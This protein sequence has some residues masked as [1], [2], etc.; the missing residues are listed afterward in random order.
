MTTALLPST[1]ALL[2]RVTTALAGLRATEVLSDDGQQQ[3]H[4]LE[5]AVGELRGREDQAPH[6]ALYREGFALL[7]A[8]GAETGE[9]PDAMPSG[10]RGAE[11][12]AL[13]GSLLARLS[14]QVETRGGRRDPFVSG[15]VEWETA[16]HRLR[17]PVSP[18]PAP[19][20][21]RIGRDALASYLA[22]RG[23]TLVDFRRLVGGFQKD[24]IFLTVEEGGRRRDLV[25][26]AEKS[27]RFV[28]L[29]ASGVVEEFEILKVVHAEGVPSAEPL[30][31]EPDESALGTRFMVMTRAP[32]RTPSAALVPEAQ[33]ETAWRAIVEALAD[34]HAIAPERFADSC[35][36]H[37]LGHRDLRHN[38]IAA[39]AS[40]ST[41]IWTPHLTASPLTSHL[42]AWLRA[43][44]PDSDGPP[45]L[46]HTDYG[47]HNMVVDGARVGGVLDWESVR[48]GDPAED[49][50]YLLLY[51]QDRMDPAKAKHWYEARSGRHVPDKAIAYFDV[52]NTIKLV[53]GGAFSAALVENRTD[54][55]LGWSYLASYA[56]AMGAD[57]ARL[58][59]D[60]YHESYGA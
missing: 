55:A 37:W 44:A 54:A 19:E 31:I 28:Q 58:A 25:V 52:Y 36:G 30:W 1:T 23:M 4:F 42:L 60:K 8:D 59:L 45:V 49:L 29:D 16:L 3:L 33:D 18:A 20:R 51:A 32:G 10:L 21:T 6:A 41:Q 48:M 26:R 11:R 15:V 12:E 39:V 57:A 50:S 46:L 40:W 47:P 53:M 17:A 22:G 2:D 38:T 5:M 24:T 7:A 35:V 13:M 56:S 34:I 9:L 43:N 14:R 27:D